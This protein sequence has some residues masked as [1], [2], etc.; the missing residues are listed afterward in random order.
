MRPVSEVSAFERRDAAFALATN[1]RS[2]M[3]RISVIVKQ[4]VHF[5]AVD[6]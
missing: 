2:S 6:L 1:P 5:G 3:S 4:V